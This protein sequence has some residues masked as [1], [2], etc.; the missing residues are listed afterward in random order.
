MKNNTQLMKWDKK[1]PTEI[2]EILNIVDFPVNPFDVAMGMGI[3]V[4]QDNDWDKFQLDG[5]IYIGENGHPEIWINPLIS[6]NRQNFT[7]AHEIGHLVYDVIPNIEKF[8]DPI[9][10]KYTSLRR[11][12]AKNPME[13]R[14]NKFAS[15][16]LM[17]SPLLRREG[18][19]IIN[20]YIEENNVKIMDK[21]Y[22]IP[23]ISK[24]AQ[25]SEEAM[26]YR[27]INLGAI[28]N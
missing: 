16:L 17:P 26:K 18:Q 21:K 10:D 20:S 22:F 15:E 5:E 6:E 1:T 23:I 13:R 28:K 19:K 4:K 25:V 2:L 3:E 12:G 14:A 11:D 9:Q 8:K 24:I 7:L 27:L